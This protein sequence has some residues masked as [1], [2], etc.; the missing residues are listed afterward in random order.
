MK[1]KKNNQ[2]EKA[3]SEFGIEFGDLNAAKMY[4]LQFMNTRPQQEENKTE[5]KC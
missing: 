3:N 1:Q 4:E 5:K 2:E